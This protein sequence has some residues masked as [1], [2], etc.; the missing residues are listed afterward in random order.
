VFGD[1][2]PAA[3]AGFEKM[4]WVELFRGAYRDAAPILETLE[5]ARVYNK[6]E[7]LGE[8]GAEPT[9]VVVLV[10]SSLL[11]RAQLLLADLGEGSSPG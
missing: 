2:P 4:K 3:A 7:L 5:T 8:G 6:F 11:D 10:P 1:L 9:E